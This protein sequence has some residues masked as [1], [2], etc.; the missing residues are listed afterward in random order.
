M[1]PAAATQNKDSDEAIIVSTK[2]KAL[3]DID[4]RKTIGD[5]RS[6]ILKPRRAINKSLDFSKLGRSKQIESGSGIPQS[7]IGSQMFSHVG[8]R[9]SGAQHKDI[10][11]MGI[12]GNP[13]PPR[14]M[15][16]KPRMAESNL[17]NNLTRYITNEKM[18][19]SLKMASMKTTKHTTKNLH[20]QNDNS[21]YTWA[22]I[23]PEG[24]ELPS[25]MEEKAGETMKFT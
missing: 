14:M 18:A 11:R 5:F 25:M 19:K 22:T 9:F 20:G 21:R 10:L 24:C 12:K 13:S 4:Q 1:Q 2:P 15:A 23:M 16:Y 3:N 8:S 6:V 17:V 7:S